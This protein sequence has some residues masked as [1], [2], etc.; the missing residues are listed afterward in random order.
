MFGFP[1]VFVLSFALGSTEGLESALAEYTQPGGISI[2]LTATATLAVG[3]AAAIG[4]AVGL[5]N[6]VARVD[7][8]QVLEMVRR[9]YGTAMVVL[10]IAA[11]VLAL[12]LPFDAIIEFLRREEVRATD[13]KLTAASQ[14][15]RESARGTPSDTSLRGRH[16]PLQPDS[17]EH[18]AQCGA[19]QASPAMFWAM[20]VNS[21]V[22]CGMI[23][24]SA[25][26]ASA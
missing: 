22:R 26:V 4:A 15:T 13:R 18:P 23:A 11:A 20:S 8:E 1:A 12:L 16:L 5:L 25:S 21:K 19:P 9:R 2:W 14:S 17:A 7:S 6:H 10:V 3:L 24:C